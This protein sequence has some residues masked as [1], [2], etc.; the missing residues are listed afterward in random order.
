[1]KSVLSIRNLTV[2]LPAMADRAHAVENLTLEIRPKE[3]VCI[4]GESGS[5]KSI[6]SFATLGLLPSALVPSSGEIIFEGKDLLKSKPSE[7]AKLRG[8]RMA[9]I[10]QEPMSALNPCYSVGNQIE[11]MFE[12]HT[13][14]SKS[15]RKAATLKLLEEVQLPEPERLY[16]SYPHQLSGGQRQRIVIAMALALDPV[17]LIADEPTTALDLS[18]QAQILH[19]IKELRE[20]HDAGIMFVTHDFDVV[21]EIADRV[22]VMKQG[23][24]VEQGLAD[25]VL[26]R[27]THPYTRMLIDAVPRRTQI[28]HKNVADQPEV[29][30]VEGLNK[31]YHIS[32]SMFRASRTVEACKDINFSVRKGETIGIVG[33]SGSGKSTLVKCLIRLEDPETGAVWVGDDN[34]AQ[35]SRKDLHPYRKEIQIVFQDPYGSLNPRRT[36]GD[37]LVEGPVNFGEN[38]KEAMERAKELM[39]IVRLDEDMLNRYPNQFSGGQRQRICI[40]RA[41][42]VRPKVLIA[43][44]AVSALDVSVQKEVLKLLNEIRDEMGLTVL[45]ITHDLRVAAQICDN[46][47]VMEQGV[48]VER[49]TVDEVFG[50]PSHAYTRK[51]LDAQPG[52]DW[53]VPDISKLPPI[54]AGTLL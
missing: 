42:M 11:E 10:F 36:I 45:F 5:G 7:H 6:T 2:D 18:T 4:V 40:A 19:L 51:L 14:L 23:R 32:G 47:L 29:L 12:Q 22:V 24:I 39:R 9:M 16:H 8:S 1:M 34:I 31:T 35:F 53:V 30:R 25:D 26:C 33:E 38:R 28:A 21:A 27:P 17:L 43:D 49:G 46:L 50:N 37:Q 48:I 15:D 20:R 3:I 54:A 13:K 41:L 44:E 52:K